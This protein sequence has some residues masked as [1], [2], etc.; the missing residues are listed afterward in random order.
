MFIIQFI[1]GFCM[2]LA[3]SVPGESGGTIAFLLGFYDKF[4]DSIDDLLTGTKEER[5]DAFVFLIKLGIGWI[6]GFV[7]A[8]LILTSVFESH[9]YYISSLFIDIAPFSIR[10]HSCKAFGKRTH[11][12]IMGS[13]GPALTVI[14]CPSFPVPGRKHSIAEGSHLLKGWS[15]DDLALSVIHSVFSILFNKDDSICFS[16]FHFDFFIFQGQNHSSLQV[17]DACPALLGHNG[18]M[19]RC[20]HSMSACHESHKEQE[21]SFDFIFHNI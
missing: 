7:I 16:L 19:V 21:P 1:R 20:K 3:E 18:Q 14:K 12:I 17:N 10:F 4:I 13:K 6:S 9:I 15:D 8:V 5:K 11:L 2:A